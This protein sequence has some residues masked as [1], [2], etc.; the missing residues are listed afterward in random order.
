MRSGRLDGRLVQC[1]DGLALC[2]ADRFW[3][4]A[5]STVTS[6]SPV[7]LSVT[8]PLPFTLK[9]RPL[10]VPAGMRIVTGS[11]DRVGTLTSAPRA[12]SG[13]V[14][15]TGSVRLRPLRPNSECCPTWTT[16]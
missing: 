2:S 1:L 7:P 11:P 3:G 15:G 4:T 12:A 13:K 10:R 5:T 6:R 9:V 8:A 16:T 14:I